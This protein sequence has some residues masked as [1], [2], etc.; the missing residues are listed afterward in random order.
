MNQFSVIAGW[1]L[2]LPLAGLHAQEDA[3][4]TINLSA[5]KE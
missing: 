2:L 3:T 5:R 1:M 4:T